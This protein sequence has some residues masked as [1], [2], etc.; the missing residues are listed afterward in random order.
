[1]I[2]EKENQR[3]TRVGPGTPGGE[4]MRR[5]WQPIT[6][7]DHLKKKKVVPIR[8]LGEDLVLYQDLRGTIGLVDH[9]CAHR[10][11]DLA[12][13]Y[14]VEDGLRCPY[15]GWTY[16]VKGHCIARSPQTAN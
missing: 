7:S 15:H 12:N 8:I 2:S 13:G 6:G 16:D 9:I 1:M 11:V 4:L 3:L 10:R 14:P 5:Y